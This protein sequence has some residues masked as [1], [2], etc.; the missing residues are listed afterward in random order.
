MRHP[1]IKRDVAGRPFATFSRTKKKTL[2]LVASFFVGFSALALLYFRFRGVENIEVSHVVYFFMAFA[3]GIIRLYYYVKLD[4]PYLNFTL[5]QF[6]FEKSDGP[7]NQHY[8][9]DVRDI[10]HRKVPAGGVSV[11]ETVVIKMQ[12]KTEFRFDTDDIRASGS[13]IYEIALEFWENAKSIAN[14]PVER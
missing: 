4:Q 14:T 9:V 3:A 8:W 2:H 7:V 1:D 5:N 12:D 6:Y 11:R 13:D 10:S